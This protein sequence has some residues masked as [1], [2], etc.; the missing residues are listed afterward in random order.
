MDGQPLENGFDRDYLLDDHNRNF[1]PEEH[2]EDDVKLAAVPRGTGYYASTAIADHAIKCL[3]GHAAEHAGEPFF[4][5]L[6]FNVPHFPLQAPAED[7]ARYA[8]MYSNGWEEQRR[9]RWERMQ[10]MGM[11]GSV[12]SEIERKVGPPHRNPKMLEKLGPGELM[13]PL[14]WSELNETQRDFQAMKMA[15]HAAMV[16]RMDQEIGRVLEQVRSMGAWENTIVMFLSDNGASAELLVRG[17]GHDPQ[18]A[19]GSAGSYLCLGPGWS[20]HANTPFRR[21]KTWVHEGGIATPFIVHWP[22]GISAKGELRETPAHLIDIVPTVLGAI[23]VE[24][25]A[26]FGEATPP[27]APGKNL[28]PVFA[29]EGSVDR[30]YLWWLHEGNRALRAGD[31]KIVSAQNEGSGEWELYDLAK[32]RGESTD[33]SKTMPEKLKELAGM[34][35]RAAEEFTELAVEK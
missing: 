35:E 29:K 7:I 16:D 3:K 10:R 24:K 34:W 15:I 13:F 8:G 26:R 25:P 5:Y 19:P 1:S 6:A 17:D 31:W 4:E 33:L 22:Q 32:D 9:G 12:L 14:A 11:G 20:S 30:E 23:G 27:P 18:A 2:A 21:H 28:L